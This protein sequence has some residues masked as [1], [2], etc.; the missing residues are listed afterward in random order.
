MSVD[1]DLV[2]TTL[3]LPSAVILLLMIWWKGKSG[4][5]LWTKI[6]FAIVWILAIAYPTIR[7]AYGLQKFI[8][9]VGR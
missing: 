3:V 8:D 5:V 9:R 4:R 1:I 7:I 2:I 6:A